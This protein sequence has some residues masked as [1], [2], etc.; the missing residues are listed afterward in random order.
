VGRAVLDRMAGSLAGRGPDATGIWISPD[1]QVGLLNRRLSTQDARPLANQP[2]FSSDRA[3]VAVMNGEIYNHR[4]LRAELEAR[5]CAFATNNDTEVLANAYRA[6]GRDMLPRL[7][8]QFA[9]VCFDTSTGQG[10]AARDCHGIC[11]LYYAEHGGLLVLAS[12]P[13]ALFEQPGLAR[14]LDPQAVTDFFIQDSSGWERTFFAGVRHLRAGYCLSFSPGRPALRERFYQVG[15][16]YF[17][18]DESRSEGEWVEA[19]RSTLE[20]AIR[21]CMLGDKEVGIYLSGGIDSMSV[22]ALLKR[23]IPDLSIQTFSAGFADVLTGEPIGE[24]DFAGKMA[25]HFGT[26]HHEVIVTPEEIVAG[27][28]T[29]DLPPSSVID[30]VVRRL[31]E[32]AAA[33]GVNVALSGEGSDEMFFGYD[34]YMAAVGYL[35]PEFSWLS[36]RFYLRGEYAKALD[37]ASAG[38]TD[39]FLGGGANIDWDNGRGKVFGPGAEGTRPVRDY[40]RELASE[41]ALNG[42]GPA[43]LDRQLIYIDYAQKVPENL[44]RRAEGPSMGRGVEMRFPFLWDDLVRLMYRMPMAQRIG[45]G[46]TKYMLRKVMAG[47]LPEEALNRPKSPFGLP[48]S[49]R[50]HFKGSGLDFR[51][52]AF[53]N[54]FNKHFARVE[55]AIMDGAYTREQLFNSDFV[56]R[57]VEAQRDCEGCSFNNFLWK[58]WNFAEWYERQIV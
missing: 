8:G 27:V 45:D 6:W 44:L 43:G 18:P 29:F 30:T 22:L 7:Q 48:A 31:A 10:L 13:G 3:V 28:G 19:I 12:T 32:T 56:S 58:L 5:G 26:V 36:E 47:V 41:T 38:L 20:T 46:T 54:L 23:I 50:E 55:A 9:F 17:A 51:R 34:H 21:Q 33:A 53:K 24:A 1:A 16:D 37:P 2:C 42:Q 4:A 15:P 14:A 35:N 57:M 39:L 49:R 11:P 52:P 40:I 25:R